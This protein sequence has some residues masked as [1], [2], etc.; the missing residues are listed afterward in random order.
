MLLFIQNNKNNI[1]LELNTNRIIE[2]SL[3]LEKTVKLD[4]NLS[5]MRL[6]SDDLYFVSWTKN[7]QGKIFK[8]DINNNFSVQEIN[9]NQK[10]DTLM[11][12]ASY[13]VNNDTIYYHDKLKNSIVKSLSSGKILKSY[14]YPKQFTRT[15]NSKDNFIVSGWDEKYNIYFDK[16][17]FGKET[18]SKISLNDDYL[19][20][21]KNNGITLDGVY[22][23][24]KNYTVMLPYSVNRLFLFDR[25]FTYTG[26]MD[27][28]YGKL[29]FKYRDT[30][31]NS[32]YI[33][34]NNLNPN[35]F[36]FIDDNNFIYILTDH[37]TQWSI[38]NKCFIDVYNLTTKKY[39]KSYKIND[40]NGS[41]PINIVKYKSNII[42]LFEKYINIYTINKNEK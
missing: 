34:P 41:K 3:V 40:F 42:V 18:I 12:I 2:D 13:T 20:Q 35:L 22:Y 33:D 11:I 19:K 23:S 30:E 4:K 14:K 6:I 8:Y 24:N 26:K 31:D 27:L 37:S 10:E 38:S 17:N 36:C 39:V 29:D 25:D 32:I 5:V 1:Q 7:N 28:I 9:L 16:F 15:T 21:Y